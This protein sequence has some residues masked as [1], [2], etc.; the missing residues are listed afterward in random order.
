MPMRKRLKAM[1]VLSLGLLVLFMSTAEAAR[2]NAA[3]RA[4]LEATLGALRAD[5]WARAANLVRDLPEP[6]P[7][8]V[9]WWRLAEATDPAPS[10]DEIARFR[11][12][13][14]EWPRPGA[15]AAQAE[16]AAVF[17]PA[18]DVARHLER[19][20][21][22]TAH[23]RW[24]AARALASLGD[25]D[26]AAAFA[27]AAWQRSSAFTPGDEALF[28]S[29]FATALD[30]ADHRARLD[31]LAWRGLAAEAERTL[32]LVDDGYQRLI[33]ARL[34][35][36][37]GRPGV[38]AAVAR[39]P[40]ALLDDAGLRYERIRFRRRA[41]NFQ[42]AADLLLDPPA[43]LGQPDRWWSE[44]RRAYREAIDNGAYDLAY[45]LAATH[46][47]AEGRGFADSEWH[48]GWLALRFLNRPE[49]ARVHFERMVERVD[50]PISQ[51]RAAYWA[52][53]AAAAADDRRAARSWFERAAAYG[54]TF[55]GQE[56]ALELD[57]PGP[58]V[59]RELPSAD[60]AALAASE[61][62]RLASL[63]A[64]VNDTFMLP[65]ITNAMIRNGRSA[66]EIGDAIRLAQDLGRYDSAIA[67]YIPL[68]RSGVLSAAASHPVPTA[69]PALLRALD[70]AVSPALALAVARQES[71]F[72]GA[73]VSP[74]GARGLMQLMPGTAR[75]V[76]GD[77]GLPADVRRLTRDADYNATLGSRY[78]G[79]LMRQFG[80]PALAAAG[81]NAGPSRSVAWIARNGDPR[82]RT[83]HDYLDWIER[84][85]FAETRNYVQR[86]IEGERVYGALL[87]QG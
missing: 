2:L 1:L 27:K 54:T 47:Q 14:P 37:T 17:A 84:I 8:A 38:D 21:A 63:L 64:E 66:A 25:T 75:A 41:G 16:R 10:F 52:G 58:G 11:E 73:A 4:R 35:V 23:G 83:R 50:T 26:T 61:L 3:E 76:A 39:V 79:D 87:R 29:Q 28:L 5:D 55:Y 43:T 48:A 65:V 69:Y 31:D 81:Y 34:A 44:R 60:P 24:A 67:G 70:P 40:P 9:E 22:A 77:L 12:A 42:G 56:A 7:T 32:P 19:F 78:L 62:G 68:Y 36:R 57:R 82:G 15:L 59:I 33:E 45:R 20:P 74:A 72:V 85:P 49:D 46:R 18:A 80:D 86:V 30:S 51:A 71:R 13:R 53:R 6:L